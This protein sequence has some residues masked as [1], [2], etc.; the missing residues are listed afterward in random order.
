MN[1]FGDIFNTLFFAPVVNLLVLLLQGLN[2]VG[3]PSA[4]GLAIIILTLLIRIVVWPL[5]TTQL[6]SAKKM[7]ELK[8][9]LDALRAKHG[10]DNVAMAK[11]QN[12]LFKEH[13]YNPAAGCLPTLLQIPLIIGLYQSISSLFNGQS[14]LDHINYFLYS[15]SWRLTEAPDPYFLG[16]NL[17]VRPSE[18]MQVGWIV[19]LIPVITG[20]LQLLQSKMMLPAGPL[21]KYPSDSPKE[22]KEKDSLEDTMASL[23]TQM[24]Y[25]MPLMI[26]YFAFNFPIGLA[27]Y[28]NVFSLLGI[29]QQYQ[30][31]GWGGLRPWLEKARVLSPKK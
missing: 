8:P 23:Q 6:R 12:E 21:K 29:Y 25:M 3:A 5:I 4:L 27:L 17:A 7:S 20:L 26:G 31:S 18:F 11:A 13:G 9:H 1:F 22:K 24:T 2:S 15:E 19:L 10:K 14:G 28:W 16:F 30:V